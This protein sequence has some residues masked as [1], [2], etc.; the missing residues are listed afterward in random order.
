[1]TIIDI[2]IPL[3][4]IVLILKEIRFMKE[5]INSYIIG[6]KSFKGDIII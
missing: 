5:L 3:F 4:F 6:L 2:I 1:M